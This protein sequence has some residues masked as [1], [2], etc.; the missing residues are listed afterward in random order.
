MNKVKA[1]QIA[2]KALQIRKNYLYAGPNIPICPFNL[3]E[4]IGLHV[5]FVKISSFEGMYLADELTILVSAERPEGRKNFTCAH[6]IG[7]HVL[8]HGTVID[9]ILS[10]PPDKAIEQEADFF[11]AMLLMPLSAVRK[12]SREMDLN[13]DD[14]DETKIY[15]ASRCLGVSYLAL[16]TQ[17]YQILKLISYSD[18][19]NLKKAKVSSIKER[20]IK[21][22]ISDDIFLVG[23]WWKEKAID[24]TVGDL[25]LS[26]SPLII[27]GSAITTHEKLDGKYV[28]RAG[29]AGISRISD[30]KNLNL[31]VRVSRKYFAG[32]N[33]YRYLKEEE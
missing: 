31:F 17:L 2:T 12:L 20:I 16:V 15:F 1:N 8:G 33:Q 22:I 3:A 30:G 5:R 10:V 21:C 14:P 6:E 4:A 9:E 7:H 18:Y 32:L 27:E 23:G 25:L 19:T 13:F 24:V 26:E 11:A 28:I 29:R